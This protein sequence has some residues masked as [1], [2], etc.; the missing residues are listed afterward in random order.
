MI[1]EIEVSEQADSDWTAYQ[2]EKAKY[3]TQKSDLP[4]SIKQKR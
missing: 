1:Y 4:D 3:G 2:N